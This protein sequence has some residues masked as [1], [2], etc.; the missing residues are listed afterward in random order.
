MTKNESKSVFAGALY[1][2]KFFKLDKNILK[3]IPSFSNEE[4]VN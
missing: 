3:N 2:S 1:L 4:S